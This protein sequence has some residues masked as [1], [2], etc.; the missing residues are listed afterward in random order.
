MKRKKLTDKKITE[1][2]RNRFANLRTSL[3]VLYTPEDAEKI[4]KE[5]V[6]KNYECRSITK[7]C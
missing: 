3:E 6:R 2:A 1:I 4:I 5:I 7:N